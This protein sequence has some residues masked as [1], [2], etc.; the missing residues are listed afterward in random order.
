[1]AFDKLPDD[2]RRDI[3]IYVSVNKHEDFIL[4]QIASRLDMTKSEAVRRLIEEDNER[5][6]YDL[7]EPEWARR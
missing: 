4:T 6:H 1:M 2:L 5:H 3:T 7:V